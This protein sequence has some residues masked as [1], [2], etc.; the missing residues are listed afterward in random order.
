MLRRCESH[1][2]TPLSQNLVIDLSIAIQNMWQCSQF[3]E[4]LDLG[5]NAEISKKF[6]EPSF[7]SFEMQHCTSKFCSSFVCNNQNGACWLAF[8]DEFKSV[9]K[10]QHLRFACSELLTLQTHFGFIKFGFWGTIHGLKTIQMEI[11]KLYGCMIIARLFAI[12]IENFSYY[13]R[14]FLYV[15]CR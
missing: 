12:R 2:H 1:F 3:L 7:F 13:T 14:L 9:I 15:Y 8:I 11:A 4:F 6:R 10:Y 5:S